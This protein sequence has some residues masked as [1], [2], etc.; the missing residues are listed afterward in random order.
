[1]I[2]AHNFDFSE[3]YFCRFYQQNFLKK[4][5]TVGEIIKVAKISLKKMVL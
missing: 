5:E 1:M 3:R 2:Y 4:S